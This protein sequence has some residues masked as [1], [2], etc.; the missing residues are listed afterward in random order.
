[1]VAAM[2]ATT[3]TV[4]AGHEDLSVR[5]VLYPLGIT[6]LL[7]ILVRARLAQPEGCTATNYLLDNNALT[8]RDRN[9]CPS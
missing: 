7:G 2:R 1:M 5:M 3:N 9:S 4:A 6:S 8:S